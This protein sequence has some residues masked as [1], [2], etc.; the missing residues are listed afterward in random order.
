MADRHLA[1]RALAKRHFARYSIKPSLS[2][3]SFVH[4]ESTVYQMSFGQMSFVR[5]RS[6]L[7]DNEPLNWWSNGSFPL[8]PFFEHIKAQFYKDLLLFFTSLCNK[9]QCFKTY[10]TQQRHCQGKVCRKMLQTDTWPSLGM[11]L[12]VVYKIQVL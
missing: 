4:I 6:N 1:E 5:K 3:Q 7:F 8:R 10:L 12:L 11:L 2:Q 9:L